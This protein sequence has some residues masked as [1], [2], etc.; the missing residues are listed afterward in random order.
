VNK[1]NLINP[2]RLDSRTAMKNAT[3]KSWPPREKVDQEGL[4]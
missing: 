1:K 3:K 4:C 2:F